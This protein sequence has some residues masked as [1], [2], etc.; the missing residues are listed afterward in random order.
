VRY[1][2]QGNGSSVASALVDAIE[3]HN[4]RNPRQTVMYLNYAAV[5][6]IFTNEK[7]SFWHFA[8]T[9]TPT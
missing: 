7:C 4:A 6:P 3:R 8:S 5:D 9:P 2:A 1:I